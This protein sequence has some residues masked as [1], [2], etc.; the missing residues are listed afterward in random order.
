M[1]KITAV[2]DR[3]FYLFMSLVIAAV[4]VYGFSHTVDKRL[5]HAIPPRPAILYL[6]AAVFSGWVI[7]HIL[8]SALIRM[9][10]VWL[11]RLIGWFG[12]ALGAAIP[13]LGVSAAIVMAHFKMHYFHSTD[14]ASG[15]MFSFFDM[16][17]FSIPFVLAVWWRKKQELHRRLILVASCALTSAAFARFPS[18]VLP[19]GLFY[20]DLDV[21]ILTGAMRDLIVK[22][23]IQAV[24][25]CALPLFALAQALVIY[26]C[27]WPYWIRIGN[28]IL[29]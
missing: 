14:E 20:V 6:H 9:R 1:S 5:I 22:R 16:T 17:A 2:L 4:V 23:H 28:A 27:D 15:L 8:Q 7:L 21:L 11:H 10:K 3:Y 13:V 29:R 26:T 18:S 12:V 25:L 24:Y 19:P